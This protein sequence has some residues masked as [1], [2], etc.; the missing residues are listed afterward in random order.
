MVC[1]P[2][3]RPNKR[4]SAP[5]LETGGER[6]GTKRMCLLR[7]SG[8]TSS[9]TADITP[10]SALQPAE[11][12]VTPTFPLKKFPLF[13]DIFSTIFASDLQRQHDGQCPALLIALAPAAG[14]FVGQELYKEA[15]KVYRQANCII[16]EDT[17]TD[18]NNE[19]LKD[20]LKIRHL[21]IN[22][23]IPFIAQKITCRNNLESITVDCTKG[24]YMDMM[25]MK[26]GNSSASYIIQL[27]TAASTKLEK[28]TMKI[29]KMDF[30]SRGDIDQINRALGIIGKQEAL[31]DG[32][33]IITW[34]NGKLLRWDNHRE[35]RSP[36]GM[37]SALNFRSRSYTGKAKV[38]SKFEKDM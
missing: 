9:K 18:F 3:T 6:V 36:R 31:Q 10:I 23:P 27:L 11:A 5:S 15:Q 30:M 35:T 29:A 1:T 26:E 22:L 7:T 25:M 28:A 24:D 2:S 17:I 21:K 16:G 8:T 20:L 33:T 32:N 14:D 13:S 4:A 34:E 37:I 38:S 12:N 19:K